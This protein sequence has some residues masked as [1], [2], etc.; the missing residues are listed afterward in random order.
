MGKVRRLLVIVLVLLGSVGVCGAKVSSQESVGHTYLPLMINE[1]RLIA[2][3]NVRITCIF[4]DDWQ[5]LWDDTNA[6]ED[7]YRITT[8]FAHEYRQP[9]RFIEVGAN[10]TIASFTM[11][12]SGLEIW[13][14]AFRNKSTGRVYSPQAHVVPEARDTVLCKPV[15]V[16]PRKLQAACLG[17]NTWRIKWEDVNEHNSGFWA[18]YTIAGDPRGE[19][20]V[21]GLVVP[22]QPS[23][24]FL[25]EPTAPFTVTVRTVWIG[26]AISAASDLATYSVHDV[27]YC[28]SNPQRSAR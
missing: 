11:H 9:L 21:G 25:L 12:S 22:W 20:R 19:Q 16:P 7:G 14:D 18:T 4:V 17:S 28:G 24:T 26:S 5:V 10:E 2:P 27:D 3:A 15:M 6:G 23:F 13:V 1:A 8:R